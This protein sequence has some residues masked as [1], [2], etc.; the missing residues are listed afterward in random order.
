MSRTSTILFLLLATAVLSVTASAQ[1]RPQKG[2]MLMNRIGP[3]A[4]TLYVA[5][6]DGSDD[7][8]LLAS[9]GFDY[10]AS[11]SADGR[12]I[13]FTSERN[14]LGQADI[15]RV[16]SDGTGLERL[17]D[18]P[19]L[20]DQAVLSPNGSTVAFVSTRQ[21]G[22]ANVWILDPGSASCSTRS[23]SSKRGTR[24]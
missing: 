1:S 22:K 12:W 9:S 15:Y 20:D 7:H 17:T 6:A 16:R 4:S 13:V 21:T 11:Y 5:N 19:A 10:H 24:V 18:S 2:V 14:G 8:E 23:R 3:S